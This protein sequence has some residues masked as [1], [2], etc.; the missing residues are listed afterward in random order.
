MHSMRSAQCAAT[1]LRTSTTWQ[2]VRDPA[3]LLLLVTVCQCR[4]STA[5]AV[6]ANHTLHSKL[7]SSSTHQYTNT[8]SLPGTA[9]ADCTTKLRSS[10]ASK[11]AC[12]FAPQRTLSAAHARSAWH[13]CRK[14][15]SIMHSLL[16]S[17]GGYL[18][19]IRVCSPI[20]Q[21]APFHALAPSPCA[22]A[23]PDL[24]YLFV[25][26]CHDFIQQQHTAWLG[27]GLFVQLHA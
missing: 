23:L 12:S 5:A 20:G 22:V 13:R 1:G 11:S 27:P 25:F 21:D 17:A 9:A 15:Q 18:P 26:L 24:V 8:S 6:Q 3:L 2:I 10:S 19:D 4:C 14:P 16:W 7:Q